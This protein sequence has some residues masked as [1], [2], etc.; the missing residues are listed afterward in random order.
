MPHSDRTSLSFLSRRQAKAPAPKAPATSVSSKSIT[1][2]EGEKCGIAPRLPG[3]KDEEEVSEL[4]MYRS[5]RSPA[6]K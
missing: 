6:R 3:T 1:E 2:E 4:P 5:S